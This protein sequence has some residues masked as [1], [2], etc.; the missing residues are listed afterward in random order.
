MLLEQFLTAF[1]RLSRFFVGAAFFGIIIAVLIQLLGRNAFFDSPVW[2]EELTR[3]GLLYLTAFGLGPSLR[4]G[5][6]VNVD[7]FC[8]GLAGRKPWLLRLLSAVVMATMCIALL[9]PAWQFTAIGSFQTSPALGWPM[10]LVHVSMLIALVSLLIYSVA[11]IVGMLIGT[12][13]GLPE[14]MPGEEP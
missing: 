1:E 7:L 3:F 4:T 9:G 5:D 12:T 14:H 13:D 6:L 11:R 10:S 2:T 8:E